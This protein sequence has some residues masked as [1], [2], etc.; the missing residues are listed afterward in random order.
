L[1][2]L[3]PTVALHTFALPSSTRLRDPY[4]NHEALTEVIREWEKLGPWRDVKVSANTTNAHKMCK[5]AFTLG[6]A[7][8]APY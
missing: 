5:G 3:S 7:D 8:L 2:K 1:P 6:N 4:H